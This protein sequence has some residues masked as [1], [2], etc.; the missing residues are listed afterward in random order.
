MTKGKWEVKKIIDHWVIITNEE[1]YKSI[2]DCWEFDFVKGT[3]ETN[4]KQIVH[5]HNNF[6]PMLEALKDM[7][8]I[9]DRFRGFGLAVGTE[10]V[11]R[12]RKA[13]QQ[14]KNAKEKQNGTSIKI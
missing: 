10:Y 9:V 5:E 3:S 12:V 11:H 1:N 14:I 7:M 6:E 2:A 4:A 13:H 8:S